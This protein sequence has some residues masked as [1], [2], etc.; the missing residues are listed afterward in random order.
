M[1]TI[2]CS[3]RFPEGRIDEFRKYVAGHARFWN[4]RL[5]GETMLS[6]A[7]PGRM[8]HLEQGAA[9]DDHLPALVRKARAEMSEPSRG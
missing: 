3:Q 8:V 1:F 9:N 6:T 2:N 5:Y 7:G 4:E